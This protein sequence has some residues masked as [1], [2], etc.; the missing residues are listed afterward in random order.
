M[1]NFIYIMLFLIAS[2]IF[3]FGLIQKQ[4]LNNLVVDIIEDESPEQ[5]YLIKRANFLMIFGLLMLFSIIA[6]LFMPS[7]I[8]IAGFTALVLYI[9]A[10]STHVSMGVP[11]SRIIRVGVISIGVIIMSVFLL[12]NFS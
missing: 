12:H 3:F 2:A 8:A 6:V 5:E 4:R 10:Y 7:F 1:E 11:Y 9:L